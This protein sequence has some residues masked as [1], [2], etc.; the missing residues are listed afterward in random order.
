MNLTAGAPLTSQLMKVPSTDQIGFVSYLLSGP[1]RGCLDQEMRKQIG[2][3]MPEG[4]QE[5]FEKQPYAVLTKFSIANGRSYSIW[6]QQ[7]EQRVSA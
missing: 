3:R 4:D 1:H 7:Y 2:A 5:F 6:M